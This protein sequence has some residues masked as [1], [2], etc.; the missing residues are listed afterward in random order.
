MM[1]PSPNPPQRARRRVARAGAALAA[2]ALLATPA[3]LWAAEEGHEA[4]AAHGNPWLDLLWKA[5]NLAVL[6][7]IIYWA[8]RRP[9]A[10]GLANLAKTTRDSFLATRKSAE[11]ADA[12]LV[13]QKRKITALAQDLA[14]M[15]AEARA[16]VEREKQRAQAEA[17]AHAAKVAEAIQQQIEQ[18]VA[19]ARTALRAELA[20]QTVKLAEELIRKQV[21]PEEQ[22]RLVNEYLQQL[23]ARP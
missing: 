5:I 6:V 12:A 8:A 1:L 14:R 19:K 18:E 23:G 16:D 4:A 2:A 13:E 22:K 10:K 17:Q 9:I 11:E 21:S 15:V 20:A 7:A 3:V